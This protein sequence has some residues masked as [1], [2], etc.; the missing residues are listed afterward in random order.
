[1]YKT[2]G[3]KSY[4]FEPHALSQM[5]RRNIRQQDIED[6][7]D[8]YDIHHYDQKGND[9]FIRELGDGRRVRVVV[10]KDSDPMEIITAIIL[11]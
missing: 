3:G 4:R 5:V 10:E 11:D 8:N 1:M 6:T 2:G 9:C 7:L